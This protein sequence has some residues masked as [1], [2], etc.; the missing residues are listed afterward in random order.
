MKISVNLIERDNEFIANCPELDI[1]CYAG[2]K[3]DA[4][5]RIQDIINFY[6]ESAQEF[7]LDVESMTELVVDGKM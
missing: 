5:R 4:I 6:I 3:D 2:N 1:N 7:G